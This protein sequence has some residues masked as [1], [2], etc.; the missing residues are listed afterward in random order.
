MKKEEL[1]AR[2]NG[3]TNDEVIT[4]DEHVLAADNGLV[5]VYGESD[6]LIEFAGAI[7]DEIGAWGGVKAVLYKH[8][9]EYSAIICE[10]EA[11]R[12]LE[13]DFKMYKAMG[14]MLDRHNIVEAVWAPDGIDTTWLIKTGLPHAS[15]NVIEDGELFCIGLVLDVKDLK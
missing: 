14:A 11:I 9:K 1:A 4:R 6:D 13:D 3:R 2:L 12:D 15:F 7:Y 5:V 10:S 8:T